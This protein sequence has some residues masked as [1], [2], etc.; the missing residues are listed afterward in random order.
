M[1]PALD[2][3]EEAWREGGGAA[4]LVTLGG[5]M[6]SRHG[7]YTGGYMSGNGSAKTPSSILGRKNEIAGLQSHLARLENQVNVSNR[8]KE[9]LL[10]E[11]AALLTDLQQAQSE[12]RAQEVSIAAREG[13]FNALQNS[14][15]VL[16]QKTDTV[17]HEIQS[18]TAQAQQGQQKLAVMAAQAC[19]LEQRE[20]EL[21]QQLEELN[22]GLEALP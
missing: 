18:L 5:E 12:L 22:A 21:Q 17:K 16:L 7:V 13:E 4:D 8:R 15:C 6:L 11:Q 9:T 20:R 19:E 14:R 2:A 1:V 10:S 3:A